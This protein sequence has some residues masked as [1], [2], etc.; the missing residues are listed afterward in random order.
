MATTPTP[1]NSIQKFEP[2]VDPVELKKHPENPRLHPQHQID[3]LQESLDTIG[4]VDAVKVNT[5][6][7]HIID[8][9]ARVDQAIANNE[10]V[11]V[12]WITLTEDE[13][14]YMLATHDPIAALAEFDSQLL[15]GLV[16]TINIESQGLLGFLEDQIELG[17]N[18]E[19]EWDFP[20]DDDEQPPD[21]NEDEWVDTDVDKYGNDGKMLEAVAQIIGNPIHEPK[22]GDHYQIDGKHHLLIQKIST[23]HQKYVPLLTPET[24][25]TP[26]A[27]PFILQTTKA[28]EQ[29]LVIIQPNLFIAGMILDTAQKI[30]LEIVKVSQ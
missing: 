25:F 12:L 18:S 22:P 17:V 6:T 5:T 19:N 15:A 28:L 24:L 29:P 30:G 7:G 3:A 21:E 26:Y 27:G 8:G 9:H 4:W 23:G 11:P 14:R 13:E 16:D 20:G 10:T 1:R 2:H